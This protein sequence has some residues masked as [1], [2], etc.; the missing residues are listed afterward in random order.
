MS[1]MEIKDHVHEFHDILSKS[2]DTAVAVAAIK[3]CS[4]LHHRGLHTTH[5]TPRHSHLPSVL[6]EPPQ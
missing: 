3:V 4:V 5:P 1:A 2:P 6:A